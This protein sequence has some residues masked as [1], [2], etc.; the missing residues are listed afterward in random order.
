LFSPEGPRALSVVPHSGG[1]RDM[2]ASVS[3]LL[4]YFISVDDRSR[5][6]RGNAQEIF[7]Y[8]GILL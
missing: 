3:M 1:A 6:E 7:T 2:E 5:L 8:W 4:K